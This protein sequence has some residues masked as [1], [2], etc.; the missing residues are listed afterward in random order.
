[1]HSLVMCQSSADGCDLGFQTA[2]VITEKV[3]AETIV[4]GVT[5][6][7]VCEA[8]FGIPRRQTAKRVDYT[9]QVCVGVI[10]RLGLTSRP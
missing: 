5:A 8:A 7:D 10:S 3:T 6:V 2:P 4:T 9:N 1:M